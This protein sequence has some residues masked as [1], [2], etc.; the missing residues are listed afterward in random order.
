[1]NP[2]INLPLSRI[3]AQVCQWKRGNRR[4]L[5]KPSELTSNFRNM[6]CKLTLNGRIFRLSL[7]D[8]LFQVDGK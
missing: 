5:Q 1:M 3:I 8:I 2:L 4:Q 6:V 7:R